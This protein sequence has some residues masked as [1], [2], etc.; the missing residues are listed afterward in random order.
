ME[1]NDLKDVLFKE[2]LSSVLIKHFKKKQEIY[3][4]EIKLFENY[5]EISMNYINQLKKKF[6]KEY[7]PKT[8]HYIDIIYSLTIEMVQNQIQLFQKNFE[9]FNN[10]LKKEND[11][12]SRLSE[13]NFNELKTS[14]NLF[15]KGF[16]EL[17]KLKLN[18]ETTLKN[19]EEFL[20]KYYIKKNKKNNIEIERGREKEHFDN[21]Y[22]KLIFDGKNNEKL[23]KAKIKETKELQIEF[24]KSKNKCLNIL[25]EIN[26]N[27]N[28]NLIKNFKEFLEFLKN[29][30]HVKTIFFVKFEV[31]YKKLT[32]LIPIEIE[33]SNIEKKEINFEPYNMEIFKKENKIFENEI[34]EISLNNILKISSTIKNHFHDIQTNERNEKEKFI[35]NIIDNY[36]FQN[37]EISDTIFEDLTLI[38]KESNYKK[39]V[40]KYLN[41]KRSSPILNYY[42]F[43]QLGK[44]F[45]LIVENSK[46][47][48]EIMYYIIVLSDTF[49]FENDKKIYLKRNIDNLMIFKEIKFW[50]I[51]S[52]DYIKEHIR[53]IDKKDSEFENYINISLIFLV[54]LLIDYYFD[55]EII[56]KIIFYFSKIYQLSN[57]ENIEII[58]QKAH[59]QYIKFDENELLNDFELIK[60]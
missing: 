58:L 29:L 46:Y 7:K 27:I 42:G 31:E 53:N 2:D 5:I 16:K 37:Q 50:F 41:Q 23:Y 9:N 60:S 14:E 22:K 18:Y 55:K 20:I 48:Y 32:K 40:L 12:F 43:T 1:N 44:I 15:N 47:D 6:G 51:F 11:L 56:E 59:N 35:I 34:E 8:N 24:E 33:I 30:H 52:N 54:E 17:E 19:T 57:S 49:Y 4:N 26:E 21:E 13:I 45:K 10:S 36:I 38:L 28:E 3:T 25:N 39:I